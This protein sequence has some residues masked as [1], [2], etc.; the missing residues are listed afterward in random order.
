[1]AKKTTTRQMTTTKRTA[2]RPTVGARIIEGLEQAVA[3]T[4]GQAT[5]ASVTVVQVPRADVREIRRGMGLSQSQFAAKFGFPLATLQNW[6]QGRARPDTPTRVLLAVI[7]RHPEAVEDVLG[8][9][10]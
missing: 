9:A 2:R 10:G 4:R 5:N 3:W 8:R 1:M 6:E 7:A